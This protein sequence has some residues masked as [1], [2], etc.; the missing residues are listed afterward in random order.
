MSESAKKDALE[1]LHATLAET[2]AVAITETEIKVIE[3]P[4]EK[5]EGGTKRVTVRTRNAAV[6]NAA[7]QFLKD[8]GIE[9]APGHPSKPVTDLASKLPFAGEPGDPDADDD[10][11]ALVRH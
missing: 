2:L 1:R 4:D 11:A 9:C 5:T 3:L 7:R 8:N 10:D 6:L